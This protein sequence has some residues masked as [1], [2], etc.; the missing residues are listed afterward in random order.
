MK[1]KLVLA[2]LALLG[3]GLFCWWQNNGLVVTEM[4]YINE[5]VP[6]AFAGFRIVQVSDL[7]NKEF[8]RGNARLLAAIREA[9]PD[10]VVITGDLADKRQTNVEVA[11]S[12]AAEAAKIAPVFYVAGNHEQGLD[13]GEF[14]NLLAA[15]GVTVLDN[16]GITLERQGEHIALLGLA[17]P[18]FLDYALDAEEIFARNLAGLMAGHAGMFT[19]LLS[20]RPEKIDIYSAQGIDLVF[21]GHA[22]GGQFRLPLIGGLVAPHQGLFPKYTSG[23]Y[24]EGDTAMV[25]SRG[26]GNSIFPLRLFNRPELVVVTLRRE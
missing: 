16:A 18:A 24:E 8:G 25:V 6:P 14:R 11:R 13:Y 5:K 21:A 9:R 23:M 1:K 20:H 7:H 4:E 22:H 2:S 10:L 26:L 3:A 12:F 19:V 15:A 17:D